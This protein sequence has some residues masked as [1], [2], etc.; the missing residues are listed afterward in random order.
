MSG[1]RRVVAAVA[2]VAL[3]AAGTLAAAPASARAQGSVLVGTVVADSTAA[4]LA[5]AEVVVEALRR[6]T[7][8]TDEGSFVLRGLPAGLH[9]VTVRGVGYEPIVARVRA[10]GQPGDTVAADFA[11]GRRSVTLAR[12]NV[13]AAPE[14]LVR[15]AERKRARENGGVFVG[16]EELV[17]RE[18][19]TMSEV[20][21]QIPGVNLQRVTTPRGSFNAMASSRGG[22]PGSLTQSQPKYCYYQ[23]FIDGVRVYTPD[24]GDPPDMD[25]YRPND[26]DGV[27]V[28]R[29]LAQTPPAYAGTGA[30]CGTVLFWSRSR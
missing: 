16:R 21:R 2:A 9:V 27:E 23:V 10:T 26:F 3:A 18:H 29:G 6:S 8:A 20:F 5:G 12:V 17:R 30:V 19:S 15:P 4:P 24:S 25:T 22:A 13:K 14:A 28:Y 1:A 7:R 11:L